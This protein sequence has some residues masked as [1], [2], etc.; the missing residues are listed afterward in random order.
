MARRRPRHDDG[1][2]KVDGVEDD[3]SPT[4]ADDEVKAERSLA[5]G[6]IV[7]GSST[8]EPICRAEGLP[9]G[10]T[11]RLV[12]RK[13]GHRFDPYWFSPRM[14]Y[15]FNSLPQV[16]RFLNCLERAEGDEIVAYDAYSSKDKKQ[17]RRVIGRSRKADVVGG[18]SMEVAHSDF[19]A[20]SQFCSDSTHANASSQIATDSIVS[21]STTSSICSSSKLLLTTVEIR[22]EQSKKD[23]RHELL[24][25]KRLRL[26]LDEP[27]H[28]GSGSQAESKFDDENDRYDKSQMSCEISGPQLTVQRLLS[29]T[30]QRKIQ[31]QAMMTLSQLKQEA[32]SKAKANSK[33]SRQ[34][35]RSKRN[36]RHSKL[37][38]PAANL[39]VA[40]EPLEKI[41]MNTGVLYLYKGENRRAKFV[42]RY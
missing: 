10:W 42:R 5:D 3:A 11:Q 40:Q 28:K 29:L 15:R 7:G 31:E 26:N 39:A 38:S 35:Q 27:Q 9:D 14:S 30:K 41:E 24:F 18:D 1:E 4:A 22:E 19:L 32:R 6:E 23:M 16:K 2:E 13:N 12:P 36:G 34:P 37:N 8:I 21:S 25:K 33:S 20:T 17:K